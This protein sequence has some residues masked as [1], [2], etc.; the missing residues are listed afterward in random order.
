MPIAIDAITKIVSGEVPTEP[1]ISKK[2]G[3][4]YE[5]RLIE[6]YIREQGKCPVSGQDLSELDLLP[7]LANKAVRP[8]A[9]ATAG[10]PGLLGMLQVHLYMS[11][12][13]G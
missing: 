1:V 4:L 6:K 11:S 2:S 10:V 7:V 9:V 3:H 8:R 5:K 12:F 13:A